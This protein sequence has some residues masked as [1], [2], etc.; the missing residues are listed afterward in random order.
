M[1]LM[2]RPDITCLTAAFLYKNNGDGTFRDVT[3]LAGV[4]NPGRWGT[5]A[6]FGDYDS[7][8]FLDLYVTNYVDLD[9]NNLSEIRQ[10]SVLQVPRHP[11]LLRTTRLAGSRD[12]L[13]HNNGDGTF[14][15]VAE[16]MN[17]DA[18]SYYGLGVTWCDYDG[19]G[20]PDI[21]VANDSSPSLLYHNNEGKSFTEVAATAGVAFSEDG[22]EQAGMGVDFGD[23]G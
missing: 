8:G 14:T 9:L 19:D 23:Y 21:Y 20:W 11:G 10:H 3:A 5:S 17:I 7:D 18:N 22:R 6:A 16:K 2:G 12:R 15:D 4:G 13:Y 1:V